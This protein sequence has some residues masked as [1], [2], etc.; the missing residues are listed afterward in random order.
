MH[1]LILKIKKLE[2]FSRGGSL[3]VSAKILEFECSAIQ[4]LRK[5]DD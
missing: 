5:L 3:V 4:A 1:I 2:E